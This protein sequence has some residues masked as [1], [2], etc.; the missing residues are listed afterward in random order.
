MTTW[1][2]SKDVDA[3]ASA[4]HV[5]TV[6]MKVPCCPVVGKDKQHEWLGT[7]PT[8]SDSEIFQ[9]GALGEDADA[10][11]SDLF[12]AGDADSPDAVCIGQDYGGEL[13]VGEGTVECN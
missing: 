13:S 1:A 4:S 7:R 5:A 11:A 3:S 9:K 8:H 12:G 10:C 6:K 2:R